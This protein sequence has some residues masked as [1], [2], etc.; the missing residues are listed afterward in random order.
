MECEHHIFGFVS[1][2][3]I[4]FI[5]CQMVICPVRGTYRLVHDSLGIKTWNTSTIS[6]GSLLILLF[7]SK[8]VR[9]LIICPVRGTYNHVG[10][11]FAQ[12]EIEAF[13]LIMLKFV[14]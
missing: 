5:I 3:I 14:K 8:Y 1:H 9:W 10:K 13:K 7:S 11:F 12:Q 6:F 4:F 2:T